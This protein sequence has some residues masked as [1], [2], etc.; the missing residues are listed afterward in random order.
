M[1]KQSKLLKYP[2]KMKKK[3]SFNIIRKYTY[4]T[5]SNQI[6]QWKKE[7]LTIGVNRLWQGGGE[8]LQVV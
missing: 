5:I 3:K 7:W 4:L 6:I 2:E 8:M 1:S